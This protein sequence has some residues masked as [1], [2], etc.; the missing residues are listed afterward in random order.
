MNN[1]GRSRM[2]ARATSDIRLAP[3]PAVPMKMA[4][5]PERDHA[6]DKQFTLESVVKRQRSSQLVA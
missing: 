3:G 4:L 2:R 6:N 1:V 5:E